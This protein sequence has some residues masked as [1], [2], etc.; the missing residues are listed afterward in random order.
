MIASRTRH[1]LAVVL[2]ACLAPATIVAG[3][4]TLARAKDLY[5]MAAYDEALAA[6]GRLH[7]T[8]TPRES[9]EIA[10]YQV[11]CLLALGR[12]DEAHKAIGT[13]VRADPLFRPSESSTS[14]RMLAT[15]DRVR[16]GL[17][18]Q[19]AQEMYDGAKSAFDRKEVKAAV[20]EFDRVLALLDDPGLAD[21]Q[22][23]AD[24][25]RLAIG[26]RDLS[27]AAAA[28]PPTAA[29]AAA[30]PVAPNPARPTPEPEAPAIYSGDNPGVVP[31]TAVSRTTPVWTPR[32]EIEKRRE[33]RGVL[34]LVVDEAG[35]VI[36]ARLGKSIHPIYD[37]E[38]VERARTWKFRPATKDGVPVK[39]R[40]TIEIR[41]G[42]PSP[43]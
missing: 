12:T 14:P 33:F 5:V 9:S 34:E 42:G 13:L 8:A 35:S 20:A 39:Y 25:R 23:L 24:L 6:F 41:L 16:R 40:M 3:Q 10:S 27:K 2:V 28:P 7:E 43:S 4:D 38:L 36:A 18:P 32:N 37:R 19:V 17:L 21:F 22:N 29:P 31:P 1:L 11:F 15:F 30:S 26:F